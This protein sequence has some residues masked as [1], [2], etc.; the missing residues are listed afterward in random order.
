MSLRPIL[1]QTLGNPY[2]LLFL[3]CGLGMAAGRIAIAGISLGTSGAM[4]STPALGVISSKTDSPVP[5]IS[6]AAANPVALILMTVFAKILVSL[7]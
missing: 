2:L 1:E 3:L 4:T 5:V 6:Y 7:F